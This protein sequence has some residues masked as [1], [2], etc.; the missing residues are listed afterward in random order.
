MTAHPASQ[1]TA[2]YVPLSPAL[3]AKEDVLL[4]A[5]RR[6]YA[7]PSHLAALADALSGVG[8]RAV[9]ETDYRHLGRELTWDAVFDTRRLSSGSKRFSGVL[10]TDGVALCVHFKYPPTPKPPPPPPATKKRKRGAEPHVPSQPP[11]P[12]QRVIAIDPGRVT[13]V[14]GVEVLDGGGGLRR[15]SLTRKQYYRDAH[16][17]RNAGKLMRRD[18]AIQ[19]HHAALAEASPKTARM[20][21]FAKHM[22]ALVPRLE[23]LWAHQVAS[24]RPA[25]LRLDSYIHSRKTL[26]RFFAGMR[27]GSGPTNALPPVVA[28]G[29]AKFASTGRGE[30]AAPTTKLF[31]RCKA[32]F[33]GSVVLVDEFRTTK[34]CRDCGSELL[35]VMGTTKNGTRATVRGLKRCGSTVCRTRSLKSRDLNAALNILDAYVGDSSGAG[36]PAYLRRQQQ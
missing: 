4:R 1:P 5:L 20:E 11:Q 25:A 7:D 30:L 22:Q 31:E 36:R 6:F 32:H 19:A 2:A 29:A 16:F 26:D 18:A 33:P 8:S 10:E 12:G 17:T 21:A 14:E 9:T 28:Y 15:Y 24:R 35:G 34:C 3:E 23:E 27:R 13:L